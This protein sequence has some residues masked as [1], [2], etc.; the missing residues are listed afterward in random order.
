MAL[1]AA[2]LT[3]LAIAGLVGVVATIGVVGLALFLLGATA[4]LI[5]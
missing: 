4:A 2:A 1:I 3:L 5:W